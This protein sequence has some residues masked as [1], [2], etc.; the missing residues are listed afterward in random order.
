VLVDLN[1]DFVTKGILFILLGVD[2]ITNLML[3]K[4]IS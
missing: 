3:K 1:L 4:K 2:F